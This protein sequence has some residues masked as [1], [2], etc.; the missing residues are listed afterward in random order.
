MDCREVQFL[1]NV[2][3]C[4][5]QVKQFT[6]MCEL[7]AYKP[8]RRRHNFY[9]ERAKK[10]LNLNRPTDFRHM[11]TYMT[12]MCSTYPE[13]GVLGEICMGRCFAAAA[14]EYDDGVRPHAACLS[15]T[16]LFV[17]LW[18]DL[19][20]GGSFEAETDIIRQGERIK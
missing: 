2:H 15:F 12:N 4:A 3:S 14:N 9:N 6:R 20:G 18:L 16:A 5:G 7:A 19:A 17:S 1:A 8:A 13:W 10:P 11:C